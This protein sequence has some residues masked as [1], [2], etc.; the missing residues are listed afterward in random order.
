[1]E[2]ARR[3]LGVPSNSSTA[4]PLPAEE[5]EYPGESVRLPAYFSK[6]R[7]D[8]QKLCSSDNDLVQ[9]AVV[10]LLTEV[11]LKGRPRG[12]AEYQF[13]M[14]DGSKRRLSARDKMALR[15]KELVKVRDLAHQRGRTGNSGLDQR[16]EC[17]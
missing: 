17:F 2:A 9:D 11:K 15:V 13:L 7:C 5:A 3:A 1:M 16:P 10:F 4:V 8:F 6:Q 12:Y 14:H